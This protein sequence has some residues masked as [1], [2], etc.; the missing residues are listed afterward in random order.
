MKFVFLNLP[1]L[2]NHIQTAVV[3][4]CD[5]V[6]TRS[7]VA[8]WLADFH[9]SV[10][11]ASQEYGNERTQMPMDL[12]KQISQLY[13]RYFQQPVWP[14]L[15]VTDCV[16]DTPG[17]TPPHCDKFRSTAINYVL[18]SGGDS[19]TT[20]F[21]KQTRTNA[22]LEVA[23]HLRYEHVTV[24]QQYVLP[25]DQWHAFDVQTFHSVE[26][27]TGRRCILSLILRSNP[28]FQEFVNQY[29]TLTQLNNSGVLK[30]G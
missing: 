3:Q 20:T 24:D 4:V 12:V 6:E 5:Q 9:C 1:K 29:L 14:I 22:S 27:I 2:P 13:S 25:T 19:V 15:A 16:I 17:C 10:S 26:N 7:V 21:Y 8:P 28:N 11:V 30:T 23:D 18:Q